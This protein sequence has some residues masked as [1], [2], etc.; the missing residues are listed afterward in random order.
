MKITGDDLERSVGGVLARFGIDKDEARKVRRQLSSRIGAEE[1]GKEEEDSDERYYA[2]FINR[3]GMIDLSVEDVLMPVLTPVEQSLYRRFYRLSFCFGKTWCQASYTQLQ[4]ACN[5]QSRMTLQKGIRG[6]L[7]GHCIR[8]IAPSIQRRPPIYRIYLP[9]EMPQ[10]SEEELET[11]VVLIREKADPNL[12]RQLI[13]SRPEFSSLK[14][15]GLKFSTLNELRGLNISSLAPKFRRLNIRP[16]THKP[17]DSN[18]LQPKKNEEKKPIYNLI[19]RS[20]DLSLSHMEV[21]SGFYKGIG[22]KKIAKEKRERAEK[23][24]QE[25]LE[26]GF[27]SEDIQ[28]AVEWTLKNSKEEIY[29]F[30]II[31]H[32]IGQAMA[33]KRKAEAEKKQKLKEDQAAREKQAEEDKKEKERLKIEA[34]K[35][36]LSKTKLAELREQALKELMDTEGMKK[37]FVTDILVAV[38]ENEILKSRMKEGNE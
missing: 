10:F 12:V 23:C 14:L 31:K 9:C 18:D 32:T 33:A 30:S 27:N 2:Y 15:S 36:S 21:I 3:F 28:H 8:I 1:E 11:G 37:E 20:K 34:Y 26:D 29:D 22:Q 24:I 19:Y 35:E 25:L 13:T 4:K 7:D 5:I 6:L 16:L 17:T 38:K